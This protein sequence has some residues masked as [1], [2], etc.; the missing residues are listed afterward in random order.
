MVT[1]GIETEDAAFQQ[2][3]DPG[4]RMP[5]PHVKSSKSPAHACGVKSTFDKFVVIDIFIIIK[6]DE[7]MTDHLA[8]DQSGNDGE[9]YCDITCFGQSQRVQDIHAEGR[10]FRR[11][12]FRLVG[13]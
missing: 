4:N 13:R 7:L 9:K 5:V 11:A 8:E 3:S 1:G 10:L 6:K 12:C 2:K